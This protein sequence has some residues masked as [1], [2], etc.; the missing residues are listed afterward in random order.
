MGR[1]DDYDF[2]SDSGWPPYV[3]VAER[4]RR[5]KK[6]MNALKKKGQIIQPVDLQGRKKIA[7]TFWGEAWCNHMDTFCDYESR[8]PRGRT[9]VRNGSVCHL[10][11]NTGKVVAMVMGSDLY[12]I[13]I[14]IKELQKEKWEKV[15][16]S[17]TGKIGSLIE[18]LQ[19]KL[20]AGVME[21][22]TNDSE[23]LFPDPK[24]M[25]FRC[26][27]PDWARM[28]K[29]I[30]AVIYGV[31]ARLDEQPELLFVLRG[32]DHNDLI[33]AEVDISAAT[34]G[35]G[36]RRRRIADE[37]LADVFGVE[38]TQ[39]VSEEA[40]SNTPE[41]KKAARKKEP[42]KTVT[43][44]RTKKVSSSAGAKAGTIGKS[45]TSPVRSSKK[46]AVKK[47]GKETQAKPA[48]KRPASVKAVKPTARSMAALRKKF[49]MSKVDFARL[50][51]VS[52]PTISYWEGSSG[53]LKLRAKNLAS[54]NEVSVLSK[55]EAGLRLGA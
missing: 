26:D 17:C 38:V 11:I 5:A 34:A 24:E 12:H 41:K 2:D 31:G 10:E 36:R 50:M 30:A 19:G 42:E 27:C 55:T 3:P 9:Y 47:S 1:Y 49:G 4:R 40:V 18:L 8:L 48:K 22:V 45:K 29:H 20:S 32:V 43:V 28:C 21:I 23:G 16:K 46:A 15:K 51:G 37:S 44:K 52:V 25:R 33:S 6:M 54:W 53:P 35:R 14:T 39:E 13:T 7:T